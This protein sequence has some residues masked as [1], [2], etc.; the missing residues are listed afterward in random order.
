[1]HGKFPMLSDRIGLVA[2]RYR[3]ESTLG[4]GGMGEVYLADDTSLDRKVAIKYLRG[5]LPDGNWRDQMRDEARLLAQLSHPNI[6]QIHD[7]LDEGG[8]PAMVMEY[9]DG[10]NLFIY[11]REH[12]TD[13]SQRLHWLAQISSGIAALHEAGICHRDLKM[14]NVLIGPGK[15]AKVSDFGIAS[16][17]ADPQADVSALGNLAEAVLGDKKHELSP[18]IRELLQRMLEEQP[19]LGAAEAAH[20]FQLAYYA[21]T[22]QE[23]P[24]P[25]ALTRQSHSSRYLFGSILVIAIAGFAYWY[26]LASANV[27]NVAVVPTTVTA[28]GADDRE[29]RWLR[30]A[31]NQSVKQS[32][33]DSTGL[34]L[35]QFR[36]EE[37]AVNTPVEL[38]ATLGADS[39]LVSSLDCGQHTCELSMA[40]LEAP[41]ASVSRQF[42]ATVPLDSALDAVE[43]TMAQWPLLF[44]ETGVE[45]ASIAS[46]ISEEDYRAYLDIYRIHEQGGSNSVDLFANLQTVIER[47]PGYA[48]AYK[49]LADIGYQAFQTMAAPQYLDALE[50]QLGEGSRRVADPAL[51]DTAWF[52]LY[53]GRGDI[54]EMQRVRDQII[55][56]N[57]DPA[58]AH[59]LQGRILSKDKDFPAA[60]QSY[61]RALR[62]QPTS[63][64]YYALARSRYFGGDA[65]AASESL[66]QSLERYPNSAKALNLLALI[67]FEQWSL[68]R[69]VNL[70]ERSLALSDNPVVRSNLGNAYLYTEDYSTARMHFA[71]AYA[72]DSQDAVLI[73]S[74]ADVESL[75]GNTERA[76][77]LYTELLGRHS[78]GDS[79]V[80]DEA[81]AQA[82]AHMGEFERALKLV[83][84]Q[85]SDFQGNPMI[86]FSN[87]L[88]YTLAGQ[89]LAALVE[90]DSAV[91]GGMS[92]HFFDLPWFDRLCAE[93]RFTEIMTAAGN[94]G[95]C[96]G[97]VTSGPAP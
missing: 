6:V 36:Q 57:P 79:L 3:I 56:N 41:D 90:V 38:L 28:A 47:A 96:T 77:E 85:T 53:T 7:I 80:F 86:S 83:K 14:E 12:R 34:A 22:Q 13:V 64:H 82:A 24:L 84:N 94:T 11:L 25:D 65:T 8:V 67:A 68:E 72:A 20:E 2:Q 58:I 89:S 21:S 45:V 71:Q 46:Q 91:S 10:R 30:T 92:G 31:L 97:G 70:W 37:L 51:L 49:L 33:I 4:R 19:D 95:R 59:Y 18:S 35:V 32:V 26:V 60:A 78:A 29:A 1:M 9:I 93:N 48:P 55:A 76:R 42:N 5:D 39:L 27:T 61:A 73:L 50:Q 81:A 40:R 23:T 16:E 88:V 69:A 63:E 87:A 44:P 54:A 43:Q 66:E 74:L 62:L 15:I 17:T 52:E 75:L